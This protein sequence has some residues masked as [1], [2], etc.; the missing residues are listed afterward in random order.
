[1]AVAPPGPS[2]PRAA[3]GG[4]IFIIIGAF[5]ALVAFGAVF[6]LSNL[7][8]T[9]SGGA[10][11]PTTHVVYAGKDIP[12]RTQ[13]LSAD[14]LQ[15]KNLAQGDVPPGAFTVASS[16]KSE[17]LLSE[18]LKLVQNDIAEVNISK[19]QPI[20]ANLVAKPGDAVAGVQ[21]AFLP[22]PAGYVAFTIPTS[23]QI[24]VANY[25]QPG[26][27]ISVVATMGSAKKAAAAVVFSNL[28]ILRVGAANLSTAPAGGSSGQGAGAQPPPTAAATSLTVMTTA[29]DA[30]YL[31]WFQNNAQVTYILESYKDYASTPTA[32]DASCNSVNAARAIAGVRADDIIAKF[33][34]FA[35]ALS[36]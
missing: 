35:Q 25:P 21:A 4:R 32:P 16:V 17:Q 12:L 7:G 2:R 26:D 20:L 28:R 5:L 31:K 14:Q 24:G 9:K 23:E 30:S 1:M 10:G 34:A 22:I 13:I 29:C 6:V 8:S 18:A 15:I 33:P 19:D 3:S 11:G 27:Y 36:G